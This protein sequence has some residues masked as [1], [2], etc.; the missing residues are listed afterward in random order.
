MLRDSCEILVCTHWETLFAFLQKPTPF[1]SVEEKVRFFTQS[2]K[3]LGSQVD[4]NITGQS[5]IFSDKVGVKYLFFS[6]LKK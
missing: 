2:P 6:L 5:H 1:P 3:Q 4:A